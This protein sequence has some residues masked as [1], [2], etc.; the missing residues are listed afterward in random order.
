MD[1][2]DC[3]LFDIILSQDYRLKWKCIT[4]RTISYSKSTRH[5]IRSALSGDE[6]S[7]L[8]AHNHLG[9]AFASHVKEFLKDRKVDIIAS[10]GQTISHEDGIST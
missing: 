6:A 8:D 7:I 1:G 4:F 9:K 10:H 2:L 5:L 3:G